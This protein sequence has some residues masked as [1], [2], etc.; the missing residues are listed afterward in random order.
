MSY[1]TKY[2]FVSPE[3]IFAIIQEELRSYFDS[4]II[5]NT[6]FSVWTD[7]CLDRIG[8]SAYSVNQ[9]LLNVENFA[10]RLPDDFKYAREVWMCHCI[11]GWYQQPNAVYEKVK[12]I[13]TRIDNPDVYC[14]LCRECE[15]PD[16]IEV[17]YKTTKQ[18]MTRFQRSHL[19]TPANI[20]H[21][22]PENMFC[23]NRNAAGIDGYDVRDNKL[24]TTFRAGEVYLQYYGERL[25]GADNQMIPDNYYVK[26]FI[27]AFIKYKLF[28]AIFHQTTD[29]TFNQSQA[30]YTHYK[31]LADEA[32][33]NCTTELKKEDVYRQRRQTAAQRRRLDK[34]DLR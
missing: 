31:Q 2:E 18:V 30:K 32:F 15:S 27:E 19:L 29:E 28:E 22:C 9:I 10:S 16:I 23:A 17:I 26:E 5:D 21:S 33:I 7:K 6:F 24:V 14:N 20:E 25:D 11:D 34:Y 13:S 3:P 4:G 12:T 1:Y 8:R